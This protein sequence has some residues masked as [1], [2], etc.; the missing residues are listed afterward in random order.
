MRARL[1]A[2]VGE[3]KSLTRPGESYTPLPIA[4]QHAAINSYAL[5]FLNA[6]LRPGVPS[7][8]LGGFDAEYLKAN[9]FGE[10]EFIWK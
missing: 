2:A 5:A 3:S 1:A 8:E 6:H 7:A 10:G 4:T 9:H